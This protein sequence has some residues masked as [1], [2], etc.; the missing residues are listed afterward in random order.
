MREIFGATSFKRPTRFPANS[1]LTVVSPVTFRPGR[2]RLV[3]SP[4]VTGSPAP[5]MTMGIVVVACL[6]A[7]AAGAPPVTITSTLSRTSSA[8]RLGNDSVLSSAQRH[9]RVT[10]CPSTSPSAR[11]P[12][13]NASQRSAR[14]DAEPVSRQ[15][16][17]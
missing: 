3:T 14:A 7:R 2:P 15:P 5:T 10:F 17:R 1:M 9:S 11:S 12:S 4:R 13:R 16:I 6:A 8:A